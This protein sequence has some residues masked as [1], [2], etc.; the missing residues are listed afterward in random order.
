MRLAGFH[1]PIRHLSATSLGVLMTCPEQYRLRYLLHLP[2]RLNTPKLVGSAMHEALADNW[3]WKLQ[4]GEDLQEDVAWTRFQGAW[5]SIIDKEGEP[6]WREPP[7]QLQQTSRLMVGSYMQEIAPTIH[8]QATEQWFSERVPGIPVPV[9][10]VIDLETRSLIREVKTTA[11][12]QTK[13]KPT[14]RVQ[15]RIYQLMTRKPVEH[16]IVTRQKTPKLYTSATESGLLTPVGDPDVTVLL[17]QRAV[18]NL[19]DLYARFGPDTPWPANGILHPFICGYCSF[20]SR[21]Y[22]WKGEPLD[23]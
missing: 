21:C 19:N 14:W 1:V 5:D 10:G 8:P 20:K 16:Q 23:G 11:Q 17:L 18:A 7:Q 13:P 4:K 22:A 3:R 9:V 15:A 12:K 2:E 6:E